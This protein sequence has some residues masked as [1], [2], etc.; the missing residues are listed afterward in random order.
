VVDEDTRVPLLVSSPSIPAVL[1]GTT[2]HAL[3]E[4]VRYPSHALV[5]LVRYTHSLSPLA[6]CRDHNP[7]TNI[8]VT[9]LH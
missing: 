3:V 7:I 4:L 5:E 9:D 2:S 6:S 1:R 8:G